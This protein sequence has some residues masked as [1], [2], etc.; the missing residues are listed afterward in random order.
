MRGG[1]RAQLWRYCLHPS[2]RPHA[3][4]RCSSV[5]VCL[6]REHAAVVPSWGLRRVICHVRPLLT[7]ALP[8]RVCGPQLETLGCKPLTLALVGPSHI[9]DVR[10]RY[11]ASVQHGAEDEV[12]EELRRRQG[13][14]ALV[15]GT[16]VRGKAQGKE[17]R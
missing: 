15:N 13:E 2:R 5:G 1:S 3:G 16:Q 11:V 7:P 10:L 6:T 12:A 9:A 14:F 17:E 8:R 4:S